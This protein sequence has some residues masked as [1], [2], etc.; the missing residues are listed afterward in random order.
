MPLSD[1]IIGE[2]IGKGTFSSVNI[3]KRKIDNQTYAMKRVKIIQLQEK[4]KQNALNEIRILASLNHKNIIGYKEAFF[5][6]ESQTLNIIMEYANDG[7]LS[8]KIKYNLRNGLIFRENIIWSYIIQLLEGINY[9]HENKIIHRDLK[10]ANL[11]LMKDGTLK[12]GD[13]NVSKIAKMGIAFTQAGTPYYASPEV[14]LDKSYDNKSDI[15]SIGCIIYELCML[16]TPFRGT[17]MKNLCLNIQKGYYEDICNFYSDDLRKIIQKM[18]VV[19]PDFRFS[20]FQILNLDFVLK[21]RNLGGKIIVKEEKADLIKTIKMPKN[22]REINRNLPMKRYGK[23]SNQEMFMNDE[24]ETMKSGFLNDDEKNEVRN[25]IQGNNNNNN[26]DFNIYKQINVNYNNNYHNNNNYHYK[27]IVKN[28]W[29]NDNYKHNYEYYKKQMEMNNYNKYSENGKIKKNEPVNNY[30]KVNNYNNKNILEKINQPKSHN[31]ISPSK[32]YNNNMYNK[33]NNEKKIDIS[34]KS[35]PKT[36]N[37]LIHHHNL[38]HHQNNSVNYNRINKSNN[39]RV[40][41]IK[42]INDNKKEIQNPNRPISAIPYRKGYIYKISN[43]NNINNIN[44]NQINK[45][46]NYINNNSNSKNKKRS[47]TGNPYNRMLNI[48]K[49]IDNIRQ[50]RQIN[51]NNYNIINNVNYYPNQNQSNNNNNFKL[52]KGRDVVMINPQNKKKRV[53]IEKLDYKSNKQNKNIQ[54]QNN[55]YL[56][57]SINNIQKG[58]NDRMKEYEKERL[59]NRNNRYNIYNNNKNYKKIK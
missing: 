19:N 10:S 43:N 26:K 45:S 57:I 38:V 20:A 18:L 47:N 39:N 17:S 28:P 36:G 37:N 16:K 7:D 15:W 21:K 59:K 58:K 23:I 6:E 53:I 48:Q 2:L 25:F 11:F 51:I 12:I 41:N 22:L 33:N 9:L 3:V 14:W 40:I 50:Y 5:D 30:N 29:E 13:L 24:Y 49:K 42:K 54:S 1:F 32:K 4:E 46:N 56:N 44:N 34:Q 27:N 55:K 35:R 8:S 52:K 31:S